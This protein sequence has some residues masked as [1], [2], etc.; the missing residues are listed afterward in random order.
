MTRKLEK[1]AS[2][3]EEIKEQKIGET[4]DSISEAISNIAG[5]SPKVK[6]EKVLTIGEQVSPM[7]LDLTGNGFVK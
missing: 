6:K 5:K 4:L 2:P 7:H 3:A 1:D